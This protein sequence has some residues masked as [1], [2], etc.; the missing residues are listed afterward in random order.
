LISSLPIIGIFTGI[1]NYRNYD[2]KYH[3]KPLEFIQNQFLYFR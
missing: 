3:N 1:L 2:Y